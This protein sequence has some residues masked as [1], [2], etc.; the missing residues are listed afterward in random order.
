MKQLSA[1]LLCLLA[2]P[3]WSLECKVGVYGGVPTVTDG[4]VGVAQTLLD[5]MTAAS[6]TTSKAA[7][8][9]TSSTGAFPTGTLL[10]RVKCDG[11]AHFFI[12][13]EGT[14]ATTNDQTTGDDVV[15]YFGA[16]AG[17]RIE[18]IAP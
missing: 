1:V 4:V 13:D 11:V 9:A 15:E 3:A 12:S 2:F 10:V 8:S 7:T 17:Q 14:D 16:S 18:F 5:T 6:I